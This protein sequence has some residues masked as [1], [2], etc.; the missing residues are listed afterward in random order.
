MIP[1]TFITDLLARVDIV[2][3]V[4]RYVQLR[5]AGTN[6]LG[7]C[8]FHGEKSPSFTVSPTKQFYHCFGCGAHGTAISF[9]MEL[10]GQS[11]PE[12]VESLASNVG[13]TVPQEVNSL[14]PAEIAKA[15]AQSVALSESLAVASRFFKQQLRASPRAI[16]YLKRRGLTGEVAARFGLGYAP[17]RWDGLRD[18]FPAYDEP[19][20]VTC[21][22]VIDK[23]DTGK[24]Y[25]RF[26]DRIMFPIR[27]PKGDVIGFGG[28]VIDQGEPKY[29]NSPETPV[30]VKGNELYGL[31]EARAAIR[32]MGYVL[33]VEGYMDVVALSQSG[34]GNAVATLGTACTSTHVHKLLRQT[35]HIVFSFDGD[36]AGRRAAWR[37][38]EASLP[39]VA[40]DKLLSFLFLP[41]EH[42]PDTFVR[43][44]GVDAFSR[45]VDTAMPLSAFFLQHLR[46]GVDLSTAEGRAR[47][48]HEAVPLIKVMPDCAFRA[49]IITA[50]AEAAQVPPEQVARD[51]GL[52][53]RS[54]GGYAR[55][56]AAS[57]SAN[58][59]ASVT[60]LE[61]RLM[62]HLLAH[63]RLYWQLEAVEQGAMSIDEGALAELVT[64]LS[65]CPST[66]STYAELQPLLCEGEH[67]PLYERLAGQLLSADRPVGA[68][69]IDDPQA[70]YL[71][72]REGIRQLRMVQI[73]RAIERLLAQ[74]PLTSDDMTRYRAL[75]LE[76]LALRQA[77]ATVAPPPSD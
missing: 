64:V 32:D 24:R 29:L 55:E 73:N 70:A 16:D 36:G 2:D 11:F 30:F 21:G 47:L 3:V 49:Q 15:K 8:P 26:R 45:E 6:F 74:A 1:Q 33:V 56:R 58:A 34:L 7:L 43:D 76:Q 27:N 50:L 54:A 44:V 23:T 57:R 61:E 18:V 37:A 31:F 35:D 9:L 59:R 65:G 40:D 52:R 13:M 77:L 25:D 20:L 68:P 46:E 60:P 5:K 28:R 12:A 63:P 48:Q 62:R 67:A 19:T 71:E 38:L 14:P 72:L 53:W 22:L 4:G 17:D 75:V 69:A 41:P 66:M 10:G 51:A 39:H 42:D